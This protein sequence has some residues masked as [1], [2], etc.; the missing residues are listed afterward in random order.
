MEAL[1]DR[2]STMFLYRSALYADV[3]WLDSSAQ[4]NE[5]P[6]TFASGVEPKL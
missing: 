3:G 1:P 6:V 5:A 4:L 2:S